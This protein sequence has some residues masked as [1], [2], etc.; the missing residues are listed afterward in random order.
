MKPTV[1][2]IGLGFMGRPMAR[3]LAKAGFP[4]LVWNRTREKAEEFAREAAG[5]DVKVAANPRE[6][7]EKAEPPDYN[8]E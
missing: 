2:F 1:G 6:T 7:A 3:N 5:L 4:L 8:R